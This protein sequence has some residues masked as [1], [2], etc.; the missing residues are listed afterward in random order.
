MLRF[1]SRGSGNFALRARLFVISGPYKIVRHPLYLSEDIGTFALAMQ[2]KQPWA[3]L[4]ALESLAA[5]VPRMRYEEQILRATFPELKAYAARTWRLL[6]GS[7]PVWYRERISPRATIRSATPIGNQGA[8]VDSE[9][10][11][12]APGAAGALFAAGLLG[13]GGEAAGAAAGA[14]IAASQAG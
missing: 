4:I 6:P 8:G 2:F 12:S 1:A 5:Q 3:I 10:R 11:V 9:P 13:G 14:G 7:L